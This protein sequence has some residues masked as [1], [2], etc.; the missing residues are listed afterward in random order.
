MRFKLF[1]IAV[2]LFVVLP[3]AITNYVTTGRYKPVGNQVTIVTNSQVLRDV[4]PADVTNYV[5]AKINRY[6]NSLDKR[7]QSYSITDDTVSR[8]AGSYTFTLRS[9]DAANTHE[10]PVIVK[11]INYGGLLSINVTIDGIVQD[12]S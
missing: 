1:L 7:A 9:S 4:L 5:L 8:S 12:I 6:N 11:V 3:L 10:I 2:L